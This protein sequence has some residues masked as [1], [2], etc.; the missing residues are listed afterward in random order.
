MP[1]LPRITSRRL[2]RVLLRAGFY[3]HHQTGSH[4][5]LRHP[6]KV[7]LHVVVPQH[8]GDLAPKTIKSIIVQAEITVEEFVALL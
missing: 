6:D 4:V 2:I 5:N 8:S 7:H 3:V 1:K